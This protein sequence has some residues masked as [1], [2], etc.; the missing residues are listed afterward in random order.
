MNK[1]RQKALVR[2]L[3]KRV[4]A[5]ILEQ[6]RAGK[7]PPEWDGHEL[8]CLVADHFIDCA[9]MSIIRQH[10]KR[11]RARDYRNTVLINNLV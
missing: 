11:G 8:R 3:T 7:I 4:T 10:P 5:D 1:S 9:S 6:I 2:D